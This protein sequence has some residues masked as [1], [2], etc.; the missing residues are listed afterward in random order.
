MSG[1]TKKWRFY[2]VEDTEELLF[3][4]VQETAK[5]RFRSVKDVVAISCF[6]GHRELRFHD[7]KNI[8]ELRIT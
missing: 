5:L 6:E 1:C 3:P 2:G 4:G 7:V 8:G